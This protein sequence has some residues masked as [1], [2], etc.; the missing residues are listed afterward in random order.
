MTKTEEDD[1]PRLDCPAMEPTEIAAGYASRL[2]AYFGSTDAHEFCWD[3]GIDFRA[4]AAGEPK[5]LERLAA[6]TGA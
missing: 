6:L 1:I 2:A 3:F 4:I 5:A